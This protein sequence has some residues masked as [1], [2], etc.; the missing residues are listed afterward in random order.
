MTAV[1]SLAAPTAVAMT[2]IFVAALIFALQHVGERYSPALSHGLLRRYPY[3]ATVLGGLIVGTSALE[4]A[5]RNN[6]AAPKRRCHICSP[7]GVS[8]LTRP[9]GRGQQGEPAQPNTLQTHGLDLR[10]TSAPHE[11]QCAVIRAAASSPA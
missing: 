9:G 5:P 10:H 3:F 7:M 4:F 1:L 11:A 8:M 2:A 6:S